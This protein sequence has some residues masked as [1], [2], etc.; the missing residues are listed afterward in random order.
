MKTPLHDLI[1]AEF[2]DALSE[3]N[4]IADQSPGLI[5]R[6]QTASGNATDIGTYPDQKMLVNVSV[7]QC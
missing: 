2:A 1:L 6:L 5:L 7:W 3:V 4:A